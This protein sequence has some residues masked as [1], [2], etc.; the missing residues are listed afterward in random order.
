MVNQLFRGV[1]HRLQ[2]FPDTDHDSNKLFSCMHRL[3]IT[4]SAPALFD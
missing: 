1:K 4:G 3:P 2:R